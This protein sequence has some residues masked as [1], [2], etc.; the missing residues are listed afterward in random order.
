[1]DV[2]MRSRTLVEFLTHTTGAHV[3]MLD[4]MGNQQTE[5]TAI[6]P[7]NSRA[8]MLRYTWLKDSVAPRKARLLAALPEAIEVSGELRQLDVNISKLHDRLANEFPDASAYQ[9]QVPASL[10][11]LMLG[12][13]STVMP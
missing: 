8:A 6:W 12:E 11:A 5:R 4:V 7:R 10:E 9:R 3:L 2:G 13:T 1:M